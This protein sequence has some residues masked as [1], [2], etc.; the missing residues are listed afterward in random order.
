MAQAGTVTI[1]FS[2]LLARA[3]ANWLIGDAAGTWAALD[4]AEARVGDDPSRRVRVLAE[5]SV[6]YLR[7]EQA[8]LAL[9]AA[10]ACLALAATLDPGAAR[11]PAVRAAA[12][13]ARVSLALAR[14]GAAGGHPADPDTVSDA[15]A[16]LDAVAAQDDPA[17]GIPRSRA[18]SGALVLRLDS[19]EADL[20]SGD[21]E[22][23]AWIWVSRARALCEQLPDPG[24]VVR[25]AV[26]LG[27][28][29]GQWERAWDHALSDIDRDKHRNEQVALLAKAAQL[30]WER[31]W[32]THARDYGQRA[33]AASVAVDLPWV[34]TYAYLGGVIAAAAGA[35]SL[36][37][38]LA[39]YIRCTTRSGHRTRPNRAWLAAQVALDAGHSPAQVR[40]F[41]AHVLPDGLHP[42]ALAAAA[43]IH[44]RYREGRPVPEHL[45]TA[46][47]LTGQIA[48]DRARILLARARQRIR[49]G[50]A[51]A[52]AGDLARARG[53]LRHW[54]GRVLDEVEEAITTVLPSVPATPAERR[55]L[56]LLVEGW[57]NNQIA[58]RLGCAPRTVAVHVSSLLR[59]A[60]ASSRTELAGGELRRRL[61][62][63]SG[64]TPPP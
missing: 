49:D 41:L 56:D 24:T 7:A 23:Q 12:A 35:G 50:L 33:L 31:G 60:G 5:R 25:Q 58:A 46:A 62:V 21:G 16:D 32:D 28:R 1:E 54:P 63:N 51:N 45:F 52:A 22:A 10:R 61:L 26:D 42:Q 15:L 4:Q 64:G 37:G 48:P 8:D 53:V 59:N 14:A 11:R 29:T 55:V 2:H 38:A 36:A 17:L 19:I 9:T 30:A 47:D 3:R 13:D 43:E 27:L 57:T 6:A 18:I 40:T 44:T 20:G 34:R 39:A